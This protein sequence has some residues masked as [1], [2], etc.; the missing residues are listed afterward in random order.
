MRHNIE[1]VPYSE[2]AWESYVDRGEGRGDT[3]TPVYYTKRERQLLSMHT[4]S[5][6]TYLT[7][8]QEQQLAMAIQDGHRAKEILDQ[9]NSDA[10]VPVEQLAQHQGLMQKIDAG[11]RDQH[12]LVECNLL[13][14][15]YLTR[16]S[17]NITLKS[18]DSTDYSRRRRAMLT[19]SISYP[20]AVGDITSLRRPY[21]ILDE[22][23]QIAN[24]GLMH[25]AATMRPGYIK[26][27][28]IVPFL[29]YASACIRTHL[30]R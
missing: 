28:K 30:T 10:P 17:M 23:V 16:S 14:S 3:T 22:R 5:P 19:T 7:I 25:A 24:L 9:N 1:G 4:G 2:A 13:F 26:N 11:L 18:D 8:E 21:A 6:E 15:H 29:A 12:V 27:G 20:W